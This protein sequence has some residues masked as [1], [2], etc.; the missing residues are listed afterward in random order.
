MEERRGRGKE[1]WGGRGEGR[2]SQQG[3]KEG[4]TAGLMGPALLEACL[5]PQFLII[6]QLHKPVRVDAL[7]LTPEKAMGK[8]KGT[9]TEKERKQPIG[10]Q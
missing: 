8:L 9:E 2:R 10:P 4:M 1:R 6:H 5:S 7:T 3:R